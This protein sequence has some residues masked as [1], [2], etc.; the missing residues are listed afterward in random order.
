MKLL[1]QSKTES[2]FH[3]KCEHRSSRNVIQTHKNETQGTLCK[4]Q[5]D[6]RSSPMEEYFQVLFQ[7]IIAS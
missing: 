7:A 6:N 1:T 4:F 2:F 5:N 3:Q